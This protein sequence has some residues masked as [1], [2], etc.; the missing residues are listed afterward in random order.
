MKK[1]LLGA[2]LEF[3]IKQSLRSSPR[4][5]PTSDFPCRQRSGRPVY[6]RGIKDAAALSLNRFCSAGGECPS[7]RLLLAAIPAVPPAEGCVHAGTAPFSDHLP[8]LGWD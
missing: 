3:Y 6:K 1:Q 2:G 8:P 5:E 7:G 4:A